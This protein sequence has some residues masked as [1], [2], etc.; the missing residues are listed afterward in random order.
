MSR[1]IWSILPVSSTHWLSA[2]LVLISPRITLQA[3]DVKMSEC[4]FR[5]SQATG[6]SSLDS[7]VITFL[8]WQ[9]SLYGSVI[10]SSNGCTWYVW[11]AISSSEV[12]VAVKSI[13]NVLVNFGSLG[14]C[15]FVAA[16]LYS[17][18]PCVKRVI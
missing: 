17:L 9:R 16:L 15:N 3:S 7:L 18:N 8:K 13:N 6:S 10:P 11:H 5:S 4:F 14:W 1:K 2:Q 12:N